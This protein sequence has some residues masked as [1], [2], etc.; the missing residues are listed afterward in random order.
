M[1]YIVSYSVYVL[2]WLLFGM[3]VLRARL[4]PRVAAM[5]LMI[6]ALLILIPVPGPPIVFAVAVA[7]LGFVLFTGR[8]EA[9]QQPTTRVS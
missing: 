9:A 7:W 2:G 8:S 5:L 4:Y 1:A 6:G 3:A